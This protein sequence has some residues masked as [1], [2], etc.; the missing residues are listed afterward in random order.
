MVP[1]YHIYINAVGDAA[2][3]LSIKPSQHLRKSALALVQV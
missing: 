2:P 3:I 1:D